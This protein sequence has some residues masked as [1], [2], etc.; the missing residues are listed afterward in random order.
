MPPPLD[1]VERRRPG[2]RRARRP[3]GRA[4]AVYNI[5]DTRQS[6]LQRPLVQALK[7]LDHPAEAE[8]SVH[9]SY[10]MVALSRNTARALGHGDDD[11]GKPFVEVSGRK[12][13]GVKADDLLDQVTERAGQEVAIRHPDLRARER[14]RIAG[15]IATAAVRYFTIKLSRGKVIA[16]DIDEALSFEKETGPYLPYATVRARKILQKLRD[17]HGLDTA[18][19]LASLVTMP[20]GPL[21]SPAGDELW[22]LVLKAPRL[23]EIADQAVRTLELSVLAKYAFALAQRFSGFY[24]SSPVVAEADE[25]TRNWRATTVAWFEAQMTRALALMDAGAGPDVARHWIRPI[26]AGT[27]GATPRLRPGEGDHRRRAASAALL[28]DATRHPFH[29][30]RPR[31]VASARLAVD[32]RGD[33][34]VEGQA[35][36]YAPAGNPDERHR[37]QRV[38]GRRGHPFHRGRRPDGLTGLFRL[39]HV[40]A[41]RFLGVHQDFIDRGAHGDDARQVRKGNAVGA[42]LAIDQRRIPGHDQLGPPR[43]EPGASGDWRRRRPTPRT[44][45]SPNPPFGQWSALRGDNL[46]C[47]GSVTMPATSGCR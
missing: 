30:R 10:E 31:H 29:E 23:D 42:L 22:G 40:V 13:L 34:L 47:R 15:I 6:Y 36:A 25:A 19:V 32:E 41:Q 2:R 39:N 20:G 11:D 27:V 12:G 33:A 9:F 4:A 28:G 3:F 17:R 38:S 21:A 45:A 26:T 1:H 44:P 14:R 18:D 46:A 35:G 8:R 16:F 7:A 24:H 43:P 37:D 5:I